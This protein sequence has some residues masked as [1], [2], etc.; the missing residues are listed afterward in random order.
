MALLSRDDSTWQGVLRLMS[1]NPHPFGMR[2]LSTFERML[3]LRDQVE[4]V[5]FSV[6]ALIE[7]ATTQEE[8]QM[9]LALLQQ[10]HPLF[11]ASIQTDENGVPFFREEA[12][13]P[14]P[15]RIVEG[16]A[17]K[18]L[19]SEIAREISKPFDR[20]WQAPLARAT[21]LH[22]KNRCIVI[23]VAHHSIADA[24]SLAYA[25]RDLVHAL[26]GEAL[27]PLPVPPTLEE[28]LGI[29][30]DPAESKT[31][32][33]SGSIKPEFF[34]LVP[35][36]ASLRLSNELTTGLRERAQ[37][38]RTS[39]HAALLA[40]IVFAAKKLAVISDRPQ[41]TLASPISLRKMLNQ[42][43]ICTLLTDLGIQDVSFPES[44]DFWDL[45][46][47]I[48]NDLAPQQS[49]ER[50][51][52]SRLELRRICANASDGEAIV[53]TVRQVVRPDFVLSNLGNLF[54]ESQVLEAQAGKLRLEAIWGPA[55]LMG[56]REDQQ[57]LGAATA[58]G[59]LSLLYSSYMPFPRFLETLES[60]LAEHIQ[61]STRAAAPRMVLSA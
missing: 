61:A 53:Q 47:H 17:E 48:K 26:A 28:L 52:G 45:A 40:S 60:T 50:I 16:N 33:V 5:H 25:I 14:I 59:R 29:V 31:S 43:D 30:E 39:V 37:R 11:R 41:L 58:N 9:A 20:P 6:S 56:G 8:W 7:G 49:L 10:R 36:V 46:R 24:I 55:V 21:V 54:P 15:L 44:G 32:G 12:G 42:G 1:T 18:Q 13:P 23:L 19:E 3:W 4:P 38:E 2:P 27:E 35:R 51:A 57:F 22:E 34:K